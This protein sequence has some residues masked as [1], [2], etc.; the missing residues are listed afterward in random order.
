MAYTDTFDMLLH[1]R[2]HLIHI[3]GCQLKYLFDRR[4]WFEFLPAL[5][6]NYVFFYYC[7]W[8]LNLDYSQQWMIDL[9]VFGI[10]I[11]SII[12]AWFFAYVR[13]KVRQPRTSTQLTPEQHNQVI[14]RT[15]GY[16][17]YQLPSN[18]CPECGSAFDLNNPK[19]YILTGVYPY[20]RLLV[21]TTLFAVMFFVGGIVVSAINNVKNGFVWN[22][23]LGWPFIVYFEPD[24]LTLMTGQNY[25]DMAGVVVN[26]ICGVIFGLP[27]AIVLLLVRPDRLKALRSR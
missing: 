8:L 22:E 15:C 10:Y 5:I 12:V 19:T 4:F 17:L 3:A 6:I 9:S 25:F 13:W 23:E 1:S 27:C 18:T 2:G 7:F 21:L 26:L 14:C 16:S 20:G 11:L 24:Y